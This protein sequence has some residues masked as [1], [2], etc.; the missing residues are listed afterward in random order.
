[1][2]RIVHIRTLTALTGCILHIAGVL[3]NTF[4]ICFIAAAIQ[5]GLP[6]D[7][8]YPRPSTTGGCVSTRTRIS[9][10]DMLSWNPR[11]AESRAL[12]AM[13]VCG[14]LRF[15]I[16]LYFTIIHASLESAFQ[17]ERRS[18]AGIRIWHE[19]LVRWIPLCV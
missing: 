13:V 17:F 4:Y 8:L 1:M 10:K 19:V 3:D 6:V 9:L 11:V 12:L 7:A 16:I 15:T 5:V 14:I 18:I 2:Y